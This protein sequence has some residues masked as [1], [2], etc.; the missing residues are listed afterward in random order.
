MSL[1]L[2]NLKSESVFVLQSSIEYILG[3]PIYGEM[4]EIHTPHSYVCVSKSAK[5]KRLS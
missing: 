3:A 2:Y 5:I 1:Q 4:N